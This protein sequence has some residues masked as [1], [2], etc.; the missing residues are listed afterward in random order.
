MNTFKLKYFF[1]VDPKRAF[2]EKN[3]FADSAWKDADAEKTVSAALKIKRIINQKAGSTNSFNL[4]VEISYN[5]NNE[6]MRML[7][8]LQEEEAGVPSN[9]SELCEILQVQRVSLQPSNNVDSSNINI[10]KL[11][12]TLCPRC[13][14]F[15]VENPGCVCD[16]CALVVANR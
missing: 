5:K 6:E 7:R 3:F 8:R 15:A 16:R 1:F 11:E 9:N 14:R 13:R 2:H 12:L 4:V 10:E